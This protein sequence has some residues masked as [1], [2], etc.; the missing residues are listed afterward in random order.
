MAARWP[1]S[2]YADGAYYDLQNPWSADD[3][4]FLALARR[5]GGPVLDLGCG[6]GRLARAMAMAGLDVTAI[7]V[8]PA[9]LAQARALD[10]DAGIRYVV[11]DARSFALDC[12]FQL[13]VMT[14]HGFQHLLT[15]A[16]QA[17]ALARVAAHLAPG[18]CF[19]FDLRNLADQDFTRPGRFRPWESFRD[20]D[21]RSVTVETAPH[22]DGASGMATYYVRRRTESGTIR[23]TKVRLRYTEVAV[24]DR[25]L[26]AAGLAVEARYGDWPDAP[27]HQAS[28]EIITVCRR[29]G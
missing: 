12:R 8:E 24:L 29:T 25:L 6:T 11:G 3:A 23:R 7:D 14:A 10:P 15:E 27:F 19:A 13:I 21:G 28:P 20:T 17:V 1:E 16:D 9:M 22:W 26:A 2:E 18:G 4:F 5:E